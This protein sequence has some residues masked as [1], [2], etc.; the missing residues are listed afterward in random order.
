MIQLI[1]GAKGSGKTKKIIDQAN[2]SLANVKGDVVFISNK[3]KYSQEINYKIRFVTAEEFSIESG[4]A[5]IGFVRGLIAGNSDIE[6]VYIDG[7]A[8][9]V[10]KRAKESEEIYKALESISS[11]R[12]TDFVI[13]VSEESTDIPDFMAIY[14]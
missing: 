14:R 1:I 5:L 13:T 11:K 9:I 7:I 8:R 10:G 4:E 12:G 2:D 6:A 3:S